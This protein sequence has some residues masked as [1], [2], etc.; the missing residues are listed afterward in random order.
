LFACLAARSGSSSPAKKSIKTSY[1][2]GIVVDGAAGLS[3]SHRRGTSLKMSVKGTYGAG[4]TYD[5]NDVCRIG[6]AL[7]AGEMKLSALKPSHRDHV[8]L[9]HNVPYSTM[10]EWMMD[11]NKWMQKKYG[12]TGKSGMRHW[13]VE[14]DMRRR[15]ALKSAG[16]YNGTGEPIIGAFNE[17]ALFVHL[18]QQ[19]AR[20]TPVAKEDVPDL[21][22]DT[23]IKLKRICPTTGKLYTKDTSVTQQVRCFL[24]R[25][26]EAGIPFTEKTG[27]G[28]SRQRASAATIETVQKFEALLDNAL[29]KL[30]REM[31][32]KLGLNDVGNFDEFCI[33]LCDFATKGKFVFV[34]DGQ[35][36]H[37][38][39][40]YEQSP[41]IT[42]CWGYVG[43]EPLEFLLISI[44]SD[45]NLPN[46][47]HLELAVGKEPRMLLAQSSN[48]WMTDDIKLAAIK[49]WVSADSKTNL[50][51]TY[52]VMNADGH[53]SN[54]RSPEVSRVVREGKVLFAVTPAH[55]TA[56][57]MQ[58]LDLRGGL[59]ARF[60]LRFRN[61]MRKQ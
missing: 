40:P 24:S 26:E 19:S 22:R 34:D 59:I 8:P 38:I 10:K 46:E 31:G 37:V 35:P 17:K 1:L 47:K 2:D 44:G 58:Q 11:D 52:K 5:F 12:R 14:K 7:E 48:G 15:T 39:V 21:L 45:E 57:G 36:N 49:H 51:A 41:H 3:A 9:V 23:C 61:L 16:G 13:R 56:K 4:K 27:E 32:I 28:L 30:Q 42:G 20:G 60:K 18:K 25:A 43:G 29:M 6:A 54:T 50:G 33:D 55:C 53:Q